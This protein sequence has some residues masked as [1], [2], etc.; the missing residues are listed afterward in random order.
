MDWPSTAIT[1]L[2][3][4]FAY[5]LGSVPVGFLVVRKFKSQDLRKVGGGSPSADLVAAHFG[6]RLGAFT[7]ALNVLKGVAIVL[8]VQSFNGSFEIQ[9][10]AALFCVA[11]H[12]FP[13]WLRFAGG[14]GVSAGWGAM[15][16][17]AP[18]VAVMAMGIFLIAFMISRLTGAS[19][20]AAN[21]ATFMGSVVLI[22]NTN[23]NLVIL[24]IVIL[25]FVRHYDVF[26]GI[27]KNEQTPEGAV[28]EPDEWD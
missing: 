27:F 6:L 4:G 17:L 9:A 12:C 23:V 20:L 15:L 21:L 14:R 18:L 11:G 8:T 25:I 24:A 2:L 28:D 26:K 5:L 16:V 1:V 13:V 19:A 7:F 10:L 22:D 3:L